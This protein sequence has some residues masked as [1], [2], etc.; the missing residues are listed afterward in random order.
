MSYDINKT[1]GS[2]LIPGGLDVEDQ[3]TVA[4]LT[5]FGKNRINYGEPLNENFVRLLENFANTSPPANP[6]LGQIWFDTNTTPGQLKI[7]L[8]ALGW[9]S[10]GSTLVSPTPPTSVLPGALWWDT[11]N[12]Q[13]KG[14]TGSTWLLIGPEIS[15][16]T[17][18]N[19]I[20]AD[21]IIDT[22]SVNHTVLKIL[23]NGAVLGY[24]SFDPE[25][26]P[27]TPITG[28]T[29][30]RPGLN[31][32]TASP[33]AGLAT[34]STLIDNSGIRP[35]TDN[36]HDLGTPLLRFG[37]AYAVTYHGALQG[38]AATATTAATA[39][40]LDTGTIQAD[41][42]NIRPATT[43][44]TNVGTTTLRFNTVFANTV[45][46][47]T[48][49]G[50]AAT[51]SVATTA[52]ALS[53]SSWNIDT[54]NIRP[55]TNVTYD[56]GTPSLRVREIYAQTVN[57]DF[58]V[59]AAVSSGTSDVAS[60]LA[61]PGAN[62]LIIN[63]TSYQPNNNNQV[64]IGTAGL[65]FRTVFAQTFNGSL[66]G[67][68]TTA[69]TAAGLSTTVLTGDNT[70]FR[71]KTNNTTDIGTAGLRFNTVYA[72]TV[73]ATTFTGNAAS[74][75]TATSGITQPLGTN[76]TTLATTA[77]VQ[78]ATN[79]AMPLGAI[80]MWSGSVVSIP[81]GWRLCD[82]GG[83]TP[84]L[85]D[86]F[87]VGAGGSYT[88][89]ATGGANSTTLTTSDLPSHTHSVSVSGTTGNTSVDHTHTLSGSTNSAGAHTHFTDN[90]GNFITG[91]VTAETG[92]TS[93]VFVD[94]TGVFSVEGGNNKAVKSAG[95]FPGIR[96]IR[97]SILAGS[98]THT[99]NSAGAHIHSL[100]GTTSVQ[101]QTH[102]HTFSATG[103]S[104]A[105]GSGTAVENRPPYYALCFIM[106][107]P[108]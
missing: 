51:S 9:R 84:D 17:G 67:N 14:W 97:F 86:R 91:G 49:T 59:G 48:F 46:A 3:Q 47:T 35:R 87:V 4:G 21:T 58:F 20:V 79:A 45:N 94:P 29:T 101:D 50:N 18:I 89:G 73:N 55:V 43:G 64:D 25:Y 103:T 100:S 65:R 8:D 28:F 7:Y 70:N 102:T 16:N 105:T 31:F 78:A 10:L 88:V 74:A 5:F 52:Q 23:I 68:A 93:G 66:N 13:L 15:T 38:N 57:A 99:T 77:F 63:S 1:D 26:T 71:P 72:T 36:V 81:T 53:N 34:G 54:V 60:A 95:T 80:I 27:Q 107:V 41:S 11:A 44:V 75:T 96:N 42:T 62:G 33:F 82:G 6:I 106:R 69:T 30:I 39:S 83:G 85:R 24:F 104:G 40:T 19:E 56:I 2:S 90:P 98:H 12:L 32:N 108:A 22:V 76:N 37:N 92:D 61:V